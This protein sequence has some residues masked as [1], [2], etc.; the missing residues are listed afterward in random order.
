MD[1]TGKP[2]RVG[3]GHEIG[4]AEKSFLKFKQKKKMGRPSKDQ[5]VQKALQVNTTSFFRKILTDEVEAKLWNA[6]IRGSVVQLDEMGQ[7]V[8]DP[9]TGN[10]MMVEPSQLSWNAFKHAVAYKR[11]TPSINIEGGKKPGDEPISFT[12]NVMGSD[13][14]G[15]TISRAKELT[16][17]PIDATPD[18]TTT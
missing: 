17:A 6:F 13:R 7:P 18:N 5:V 9:K 10:Y 14:M 11:G 2:K 16:Q 1:T 3:H 4:L 12:F 15:P 8:I